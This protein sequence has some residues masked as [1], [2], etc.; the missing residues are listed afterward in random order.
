MARNRHYSQMRSSNVVSLLERLNKTTKAFGV[1]PRYPFFDRRLMEFCLGIPADQILYEGWMRYVLRNAM[2]GVLPHEVQWRTAKGNL[3]PSFWRALRE[4]TAD[5]I[6][7]VLFA[8]DLRITEY[9]D[10]ERARSGYREFAD[11]G[12]PGLDTVWFPVV[13]ESWLRSDALTNNQ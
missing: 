5:D 4:N 8:H 2:D 3:A 1:E 6:A 12:S 13:L 7:E 9:I 11:G 10:L